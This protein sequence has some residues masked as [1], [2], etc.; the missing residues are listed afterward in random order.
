MGVVN[1][2]PVGGG[3]LDEPSETLR[4]AVSGVARIPEL[5]MRFVLA[6]PHVHVALSGMSTMAQVEDNL[7]TCSD[8]QPLDEAEYAALLNHL[9]TMKTMA[10]LYCTGCGYCLPCPQEIPIARI[11]GMFNRG[12]VYGLWQTARRGYNR[13]GKGQ[14]KTA[15][16]AD[17][18]IECG[19]CETKCPQKIPIRRQLKEAHQALAKTECGE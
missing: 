4:Q 6:N 15:K 17:A 16:R 2:G 1:M 11:F 18:C 9:A 5:A 10:E 14:N 8:P 19:I 12:R 7:R 13:I 3:N